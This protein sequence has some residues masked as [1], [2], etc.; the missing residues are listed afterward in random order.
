MNLV[1]QHCSNLAQ[2]DIDGLMLSWSV[3]GYPS[4]NLQLV[5]C[6][7]SEPRP[8]VDQAL[9]K[10]AEACYGSNAAPNVLAAWSKFSTAFAEYPFHAG[11]LYEGPMQCGPA[12]LLYP[13][14]TKYHATMVGFPYDDLNAWRAIYPPEILAGQFEKVAAGWREGLSLFEGAVRAG[15]VSSPQTNLRRDAG[16]AEA[17]GLH[18]RSVANQIRFILA[19]NAL[20]SGAPKDTE[21]QAQIDA[22]KRIADDEIQNA[23]RL[24]VLV[25][26]D[27]RIGFEASNQYYYLPLDLMEKVVNCEYVLNTWLPGVPDQSGS[28]R[29]GLKVP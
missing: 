26:Q 27:S 21:R 13:E 11:L 3:G 25:C 24:F 12:N 5:R 22:I 16:L 4:P 1:A 15:G 14:P 7:D 10:V 17:A 2:A 19:R 18:F 6:F 28:H 20:L 23:R 29:V 9:A 8:T